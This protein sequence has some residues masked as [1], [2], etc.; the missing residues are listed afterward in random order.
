M[1]LC[2]RN[3]REYGP[4]FG[5]NGEPLYIVYSCLSCPSLNGALEGCGYYGRMMDTF[6]VETSDGEMKHIFLGRKKHGGE[7]ED[8]TKVK[9][10]RCRHTFCATVDACNNVC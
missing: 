9:T 5:R 6:F 8:P 10:D 7:C 2:F 1:L 3:N 4:K